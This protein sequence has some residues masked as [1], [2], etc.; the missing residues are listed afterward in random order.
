MPDITLNTLKGYTQEAGADTVTLYFRTLADRG[1]GANNAPD[2]I[3]SDEEARTFIREGESLSQTLPGATAP[4][5]VL[6]AAEQKNILSFLSRN[7]PAEGQDSIKNIFNMIGAGNCRT[8]DL[9][10]TDYSVHGKDTGS[11]AVTIRFTPAGDFGLSG[12]ALYER[13]KPDLC[14]QH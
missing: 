1:G 11:E 4:N 3:V 5:S 8:M 13:P 9:K 2:G 6:N 12:I 14:R 7:T 10:N